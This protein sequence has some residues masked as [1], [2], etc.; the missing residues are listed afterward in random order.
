MGEEFDFLEE[1]DK[2]INFEPNNTIKGVWITKSN[3]DTL[4]TERDNY[5]ASVGNLAHELEITIAEKEKA[6]ESFDKLMKVHQ[7]LI[8]WTD[9]AIEE[10]KKLEKENKSLHKK[11]EIIK[12]LLA[13]NKTLNK[14]LEIII[15][16][17]NK[18]NSED[19]G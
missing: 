10:I 4:C 8:D 5:Q 12:N 11:D 6:I 15:E 7:N 14:K 3:Y 9:K 17:I 2:P 19:F 16:A 1:L 18:V 13:K